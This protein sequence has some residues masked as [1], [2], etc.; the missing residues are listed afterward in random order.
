MK[1][2][3]QQKQAPTATEWHGN[4]KCTKKLE[5]CTCNNICSM[6]TFFQS[7]MQNP[8]KLRRFTA[9]AWLGSAE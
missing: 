7:D 4:N 2:A 6:I 3:A 9:N 1:Q 5:K 8:L